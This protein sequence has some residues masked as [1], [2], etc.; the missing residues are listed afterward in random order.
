VVSTLL[1]SALASCIV[2]LEL[3]RWIPINF[4]KQGTVLKSS[5]FQSPS[6]ITCEPIAVAG[7]LLFELLLPTTSVL[8]A[9]FSELVNGDDGEEICYQIETNPHSSEYL[10][11]LASK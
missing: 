2:P 8:E 9:F 1:T 3:D 6:I 4:N 7:E 11:P 5:S 10:M